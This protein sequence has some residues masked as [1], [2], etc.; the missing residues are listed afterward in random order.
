MYS[1]CIETS[2]SLCS[3]AIGQL[4]ACIDVLEINDTNQHS[5]NLHLLI[6]KIIDRQNI[7]FNNLSFICSSSGP[8]SYTGLRIGAATAKALAY[9]LQIPLIDVSSL[10]TQALYYLLL[11]KDKLS[12]SSFIVSTMYGRGSKIY[13][14]I[15][16]ASGKEI[17]STNTLIL[18]IQNTERLY[19][20]YLKDNSELIIIGSGSDLLHKNLQEYASHIQN[21]ALTIKIYPDILPSAKGMVEEGYRRFS[22]KNFSDFVYFEPMYI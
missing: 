19:K 3:V 2:T 18:N 7:K 17:K 1:L 12:K 14:S 10:T 20:E 11:N 13:L 8:G 16:S 4:D 9:S 5:K 15:Y 21:D 22:S 6:K